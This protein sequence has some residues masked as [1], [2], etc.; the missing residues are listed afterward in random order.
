MTDRNS[1]TAGILAVALPAKPA[2]AAWGNH[3]AARTASAIFH[4]FFGVAGAAAG[5]A[6][7]GLG[8]GT[9]VMGAAGAGA[10]SAGTI[11]AGTVFGVS[12]M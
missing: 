9:S 5:V 1:A 12:V 6:S 7:A 2:R 8:I 11:S 4:Y 3:P 10:I